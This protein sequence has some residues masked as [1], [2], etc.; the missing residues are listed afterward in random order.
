M[1]Y[2]Y[3]WRPYVSA[4]E[5]R[6]SALR[7]MQR[8]RKDGKRIEPLKIEG[9]KIATSV[10]GK[11]WCAHLE[12]FS[13]F[14]NRLPRGRTYARNGSVCHL[15]VRKHVI[16][17]KVQGS[18]LY[19]VEVTIAALAAPRW[20]AIVKD[21]AGEVG[22]VLEL[23]KGR[24]SDRVMSVVTDRDRGLF[25]TPKEI[26]MECSCPDWAGMCKHA[27]AA[28]YGV[29]ARLD[30][31][32]ELLFTLRGVD[33]SDLV[34]EASVEDVTRRPTRRGATTLS[35]SAIADVFGIDVAP[36]TTTTTTTKKKKS[37]MVTKKAKRAVKPTV[38]PKA[39]ATR[40]DTRSASA[41]SPKS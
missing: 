19:D 39:K 37:K 9:Q 7:E 11:A 17:A 2:G 21:C 31:N 34:A 20:K 28:M 16:E 38:K 22:S 33:K 5:R 40:R 32:P 35:E 1:S 41:S 18:E 6:G 24:I 12:K 23:L 8:L 26:K 25:P 30:Q 36:T 10:W 13:D 14:V 3:S 15:G 4:A 29:G 27:A